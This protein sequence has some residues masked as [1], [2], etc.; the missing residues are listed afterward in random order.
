MN[1]N[2]NFPHLHLFFENVGRTI[3]IGSF[4]IAYYGLI[5]ASAILVGIY[6]ALH[7]AKRTGQKEEDYLDLAIIA[8]LFSIAGARIYYVIFSWD[9]YKNDLVSILNLREGGLAIFGGIIAAVI[10]VFLVAK[11][12]KI[13]PGLMLDTACMGLVTGQIIGRWGNF[14]NREAFGGYTDSLLAMQIPIN[15]VRE[16]D[17]N[18]SIL[19]HTTVVKGIE[20]IQVHPTFLYE[21][22]W[23]I[24][25]LIV[26]FVFRKK[27]TFQGELFI[28]Y[29]TLY[30]LGRVWIEGLRTD[31]LLI[32]D[33]NIAVS[34][35]LS[36]L[37]VVSGTVF[38]LYMRF[39]KKRKKQ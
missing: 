4:P 36:A 10:T 39:V 2:I 11:H 6:M 32:L 35:L 12:K 22:M 27:K 21:S 34:Q 23:N 30:S 7:E 14:F 28:L 18:Q 15:A 9:H 20:Y 19:A 37:L 29:L 24:G 38:I 1:S 17:I 13:H 26:L 33:T 3:K 16:S 8:V 5:I 31:Q 25:V